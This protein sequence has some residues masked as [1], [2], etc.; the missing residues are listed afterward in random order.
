MLAVC[1]VRLR[2]SQTSD[3]SVSY[4]DYLHFVRG[5][6]VAMSCVRS[7]DLLY[8][9]PSR[10]A[11]PAFPLPQIRCR[12]RSIEI[13][14]QDDP[15]TTHAEHDQMAVK[16]VAPRYFPPRIIHHRV[17]DEERSRPDQLVRVVY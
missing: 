6:T 5:P 11:D 17:V 12:I 15:I 16:H 10:T 4:V 2:S 8:V 3:S 7:G 9:V 1:A 13:D 14:I